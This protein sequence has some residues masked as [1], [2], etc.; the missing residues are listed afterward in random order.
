MLKKRLILT[1]LFDQGS[2]VMS[3]NFRRQYVGDL[4]WLDGCYDLGSIDE[5][6]DELVVLNIDRDPQSWGDFLCLV[7][8]IGHK[9]F[10]PLS[11]GGGVRT[12]KQG[13]QL[14]DSGADKLVLN[15][16]LFQDVELVESL[17]R[18]FGRQCL[19]ASIDISVRTDLKGSIGIEGASKFL[20][21][22]CKVALLQVPWERV[23]EVYLNSIE[24]DGTGQGLNTGLLGLLP[25]DIMNPVI[26][27][28]GA[29][30]VRHLWEGLQ[31]PRVSAIATANLLNF[32]GDGLRN[33]RKALLDWGAPLPSR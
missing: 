12:E 31:D 1:L 25:P 17:S 30:N 28:G 8:R 32:V 2:F 7:E 26:L 14:L 11:A 13:R 19:L 23:G 27:A 18:Q 20:S 9:T 3:R 6:V 24:R 10:I 29:G 15:T 4:D 16:P 22:T 33:A 5:A 21:Q